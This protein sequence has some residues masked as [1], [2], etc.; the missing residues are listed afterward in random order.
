MQQCITFE[1][2][3]DD[4]T[5]QYMNMPGV[6]EATGAARYM[7]PKFEPV[8]NHHASIN[9]CE[10]PECTANDEITGAEVLLHR[11]RQQSD[12]AK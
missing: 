6:N 11:I 10:G 9:M 12:S 2:P 1:R 3:G 8:P 4:L 7:S 5:F